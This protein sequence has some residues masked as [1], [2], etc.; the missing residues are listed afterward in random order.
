MFIE[1]HV[2]LFKGIRTYADHRADVELGRV[3]DGKEAWEEGI[4]EE[5][6]P[7]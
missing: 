1:R 6:A 5:R 7:Y 2:K 4:W 3:N